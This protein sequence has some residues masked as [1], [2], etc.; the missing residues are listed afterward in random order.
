MTDALDARSEILARIRTAVGN[1]IARPNPAETWQAIPR[2]YRQ[3]GTLSNA[4]CV[5]LL[6]ERL[7]DYGARVYRAQSTEIAVT[8]AEALRLRNKQRVLISPDID[9]AWLTE[10]RCTFI[11]DDAR[12]YTEIDGCEGVLTGCTAASAIT[13]TLALC[14]TVNG[15]EVNTGQGRR[16]LTLIPDYHLCVVQAADVFETVPEAMRML[17][18]RKAQPITLVSGPSATAD[19]EMT[20]I[21]GVHGPRTLDVVIVV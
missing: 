21:Q 3:T 19:I 13:G 18:S 15:T 4:A 1:G 14:H 20:R 11:Q 5:D 17:E 16:A 6:E 7:C 2:A 10:S 8:V 12:S 9:P